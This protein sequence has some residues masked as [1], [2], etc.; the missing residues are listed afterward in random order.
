MDTSQ[1]EMTNEGYTTDTYYVVK[2][3]LQGEQI[4]EDQIK[5]LEMAAVI[6]TFMDCYITEYM[7][8]YQKEVAI[9]DYLTANT[10]YGDAS[11]VNES[12]HTAYGALIC[13]K[14]VCEGYAKAFQLMCVSCGIECKYVVG[15]NGF[16]HGWNMVLLDNE[17]Y[18]V[19]VTWD[20]P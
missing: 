17:W 4:P 19:D 8:P 2:Y 18:A 14:A 3:F 1:V 20:D 16:N 9:H 6:Q 15:N 13:H 5:S 11:V 10:I 7:T 12:E